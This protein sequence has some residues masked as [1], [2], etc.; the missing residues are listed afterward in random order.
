MTHC[1]IPAISLILGPKH[2]LYGDTLDK[3]PG[4]PETMR[5]G[6]EG[7]RLAA[8]SA[9]DPQNEM[10]Q[11]HR[12]LIGDTRVTRGIQWETLLVSNT[13]WTNKRVKWLN[14]V[15]IGAEAHQKRKL[16]NI[17]IHA[18]YIHFINHRSCLFCLRTKIEHTGL[19]TILML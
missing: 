13:M 4:C 3:S 14:E 12:G 18:Y 10:R 8:C 16:T 19:L 7:H 9:V 6:E 1:E 17:G 15:Q 11:W 5:M 2:I